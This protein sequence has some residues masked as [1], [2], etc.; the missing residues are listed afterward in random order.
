MQFLQ[1]LGLSLAM[2]CAGISDGDATGIDP[3]RCAEIP[4]DA[5][6]LAC[7]DQIFPKKNVESGGASLR[8]HDP[9]PTPSPLDEFGANAAQR[10]AARITTGKTVALDKIESTVI[11]ADYPS[12]GGFIVTLDNGQVWRQ[13]ELKSGLTPRVGDKV[14]IES[15]ALGSFRLVKGRIATRVRRDR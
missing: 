11:T 4:E 12:T 2:V 1:R 7:F 10:R 5:S 9:A 13:T 8:Q 14:T 6:R 15:G 3:A